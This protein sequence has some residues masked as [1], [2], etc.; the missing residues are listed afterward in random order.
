MEK[1][2][3]ASIA[4]RLAY[5]YWGEIQTQYKLAEGIWLFDTASHGGI[6]VDIAVHPELAEFKSTVYNHRYGKYAALYDEQHF[7]AFE[8]DCNAQIVEWTF[9]HLVEDRVMKRILGYGSK[10]PA[11]TVEIAEWRAERKGILERSLRNWHKDWLENHPFA[12]GEPK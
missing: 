3:S 1:N 12:W 2:T 10:D 6:V 4:R 8:E 5:Q 11:H 9:P 7:A